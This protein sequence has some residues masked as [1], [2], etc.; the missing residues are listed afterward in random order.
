MSFQCCKGCWTRPCSDCGRQLCPT[1]SHRQMFGTQCWN[2][3]ENE[4]ARNLRNTTQS[5][6]G[7]LEEAQSENQVLNSLLTRVENER[8]SLAERVKELTKEIAKL[9]GC[10]K[11]E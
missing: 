7:Q 1:S 4:S 6:S 2:C 3:S 8:N 11:E 10:S 5:L 9:K